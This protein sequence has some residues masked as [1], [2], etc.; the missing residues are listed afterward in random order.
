MSTSVY[1]RASSQYRVLFEEPSRIHVGFVVDKVVLGQE[2]FF[3]RVLR[4]PS[5]GPSVRHI[6][7]LLSPMLHNLSS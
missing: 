7:S 2:F 6:F 3:F 1:E 4:F 5:V